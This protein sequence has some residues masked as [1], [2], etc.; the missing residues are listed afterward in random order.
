MRKITIQNL[1]TNQLTILL[2]DTLLILAKQ[3]PIVYIQIAIS[4]I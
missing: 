4:K 3:I 1:K 2:I